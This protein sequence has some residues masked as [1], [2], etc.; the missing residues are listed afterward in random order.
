MSLGPYQRKRDVG[1]TREPRGRKAKKT[2]R[3]LKFVVQ[4]HAA[5]RLHYDLR[6]EMKRSKKDEWLLIKKNDAYSQRGHEADGEKPDIIESIA[7]NGK[8]GR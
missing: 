6:L 1:K 3:P 7:A 2:G 8:K 5:R 4:K